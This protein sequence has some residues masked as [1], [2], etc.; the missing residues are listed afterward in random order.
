MLTLGAGWDERYDRYEWDDE[1][2]LQYRF[3]VRPGQWRQVIPTTS[4]G[5]RELSRESD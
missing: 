4:G 3:V 5:G 1:R 2:S